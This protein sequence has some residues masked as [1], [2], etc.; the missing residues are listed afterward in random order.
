VSAATAKAAPPVVSVCVS[1]RDRAARLGRLLQALERQTLPLKQFEVVVTDDGSTDDTSEVLRAAAQRRALRIKTLRHDKSTG[2]AAGRNAAWRAA[3]APV[4][5]FIDDDCTPS[6]G[7]LAAGLS[8]LDDADVVV[9]AVTRHPDQAHRTSRFARE[10]VVGRDQVRWYATANIF[11]RRSDLDALGGFDESYPGAAGEDTDLGFRAEERGLRTGFVPSA[12]VFHDVT[13]AGPREAVRD[14]ARWS[15]LALVFASHP[16]QRAQT[17]H[18]R[19]FWRPTHA[20]V[21]M[22]AAAVA[23]GARLPVARAL[24]G[25][26]LH[27]K[28]CTE[29]NDVP[30]GVAVAELPGA[31]AVD[32]AGLVAVLRGSVRHRTLLL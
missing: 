9:G 2:P 28:L 12:I 1:T 25:P 21:L 10:L 13:A 7:W 17:L 8:G 32:V 23:L 18:H 11:Y 31:L 30:L 16:E 4:I 15:A 22:L 5:A 20:E 26:W 6:N 3:S 24:A 29:R 19:V 14:Q 27:R